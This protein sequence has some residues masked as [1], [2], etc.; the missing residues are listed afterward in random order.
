TA[1]WLARW[2]QTAAELADDGHEPAA[3]AGEPPYAGLAAFQ[4]AD[5]ARFFGRDRLVD[6]LVER[7]RAG[8][9]LGVFGPSGYG[10]S[11][12]LRAGLVARLAPDPG[13]VFTPGAHPIEE[14]AVRMA[15]HLGGS[16]AAL[17]A[18]LAADPAN[19]HLRVRQAM[20]DGDL[21]LV[22]DQFEEVFTLCADA[23][24]RAWLI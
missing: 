16:A 18:E 5:A 8:R 1:G 21:V 24:E 6:E 9:F 3:D 11:S 15:G 22:V 19:L 2:R 7:V 14:G 13:V 23:D 12:V 20:G 17:R 10:K 4:P